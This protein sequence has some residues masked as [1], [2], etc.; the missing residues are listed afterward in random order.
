MIYHTMGTWHRQ[1][2]R[3][4]PYTQIQ[5]QNTEHQNKPQYIKFALLSVNKFSFTINETRV[6]FVYITN[7]SRKRLNGVSDSSI[8]NRSAP[9]RASAAVPGG[10]G[11]S[12][13]HCQYRWAHRG[14]HQPTR[15]QCPDFVNFIFKSPNPQKLKGLKINLLCM[16]LSNKVSSNSVYFN[17]MV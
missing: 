16:L 17:Q 4:R 14:G 2:C 5:S 11:L 6:N 10:H 9:A 12:M 15:E 8:Q 3:T 1:F 13:K 7:N